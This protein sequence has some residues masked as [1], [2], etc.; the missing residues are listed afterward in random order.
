MNNKPSFLKAALLVIFDFFMGSVNS[1]L[2]FAL[3]SFVIGIV[4]LLRP[5]LSLDGKEI[6]KTIVPYFIG[7]LLLVISLFLIVSWYRNRKK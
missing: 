2:G 5:L 1:K 4:L 6:Q 7:T 3:L